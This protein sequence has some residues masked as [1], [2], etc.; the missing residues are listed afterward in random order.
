MIGVLNAYHFDTDPNTVQKKYFPMLKA[1]LAK[2]LKEHAIKE[3]KVAQGEF[4]PNVDA[5]DAWII[6]G[7]PAA[8]YDQEEWIIKLIEFTKNCHKVHKKLLGICFGH[9]LIARALGGKVENSHTGWCVGI[10]EFS[11]YARVSW[12]V[13]A[14]ATCS[15]IFSHQDQVLELPKDSQLLAGDSLCPYQVYAIG[16]HI[17]SIQGHPEFTREYAKSRYDARL[18]NIGEQKYKDA[19]QSLDKPMDDNLFGEWLNIFFTA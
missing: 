2:H 11:I 19:I 14:P 5:C 12:M 13:D 18:E 15:L 10:R 8:C 1:F 4:P 16:D 6:T 7:S 3:Y 17:F 9:Q